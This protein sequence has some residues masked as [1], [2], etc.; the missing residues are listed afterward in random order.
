MHKVDLRQYPRFW[1]DLNS[2]MDLILETPENGPH[3]PFLRIKANLETW[4]Y[5]WYGIRARIMHSGSVD[6]VYMVEAE[7]L[8]FV[9][10][11]N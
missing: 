3:Y 2:R 4:L 11:W 10:K 9:L 6:E 1:K 5:E 7:Y 8:S